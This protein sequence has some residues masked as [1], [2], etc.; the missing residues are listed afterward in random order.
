[1]LN[2]KILLFLFLLFNAGISFS[3]KQQKENKIQRQILSSATHM[4]EFPGGVAALKTFLVKSLKYPKK[5]YNDSLEGKVLARIVV[6]PNGD[7]TNIEII[8]SLSPE[9]DKET[10]RVIK[11]M[12]DWNPARQNGIPVACYYELPI[13][14]RMK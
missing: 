12:P 8:E 6:E 7:I 1:M 4:P 10:I 2:I 3:Q 14:F 13:I 9:C 5:A 11:K